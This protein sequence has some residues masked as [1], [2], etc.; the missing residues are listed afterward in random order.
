LYCEKRGEH[1]DIS[2]HAFYS[3]FGTSVWLALALLLVTLVIAPVL[4]AIHKET[5]S[6]K[7]LFRIA[8]NISMYSIAVVGTLVRQE[9]PKKA[10]MLLAVSLVLSVIVTVYENELTAGIIVPREAVPYRLFQLIDSGWQFTLVGYVGSSHTTFN[11][12]LLLWEA[13]K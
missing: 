7:L 10:P 2:M 3:C 5:G 12:D 4:T 6:S 8:A 11:E 1:W 13:S 9:I